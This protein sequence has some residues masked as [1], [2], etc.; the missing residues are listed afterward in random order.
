MYS[1]GY[2]RNVQHPFAPSVGI[3]QKQSRALQRCKSN[4]ASP[5]QLSKSCGE[6]ATVGVGS[7]FLFCKL[8]FTDH[9]SYGG[10]SL[11]VALELQAFCLCSSPRSRAFVTFSLPN[12]SPSHDALS[13]Y[14]TPSLVLSCLPALCFSSH[15]YLLYLFCPLL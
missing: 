13:L 2:C 15:C 14:L 7:A 9:S 10:T 5:N 8:E 11:Y 4:L 1:C 12:C 3:V 6:A